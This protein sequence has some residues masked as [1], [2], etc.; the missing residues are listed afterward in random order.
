[1][2]AWAGDVQILNGAKVLLMFN[3]RMKAVASMIEMGDEWLVQNGEL[4]PFQM[5]GQG[6]PDPIDFMFKLVSPTSPDI[7]SDTPFLEFTKNDTNERWEV[8]EV[9]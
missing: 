6:C 4:P 2:I 9:K 8:W 5:S 7:E 3:D 1:M